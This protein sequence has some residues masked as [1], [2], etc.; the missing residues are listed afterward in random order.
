VWR[1]IKAMNRRL[2]KEIGQHITEK[3]GHHW[4]LTGFAVNIW[5][6]EKAR[7]KRISS[8]TCAFH[9][10]GCHGDLPEQFFIQSK[11]S[12]TSFVQEAVS[13]DR[14]TASE[15]GAESTYPFSSKNIEAA[16]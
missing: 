5:G 2:E 15:V 13:I 3:R 7:G 1:R 9:S 12:G 11:I 6:E 16:R 8:F 10:I 4:A 14:S